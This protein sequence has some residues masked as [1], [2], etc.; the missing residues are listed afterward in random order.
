LA[1]FKYANFIDDN[2]AFLTGIRL[3]TSPVELPAGIS[4][5]TFTQIAYL[6]DTYQQKPFAYRFSCYGLFVAYF[7]T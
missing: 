6:A 5:F 2:V 1:Y 3:L 4:F 7:P